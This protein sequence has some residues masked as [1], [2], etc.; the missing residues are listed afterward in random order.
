MT[1]ALVMLDIVEYA[2]KNLEYKMGKCFEIT[3]GRK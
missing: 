3:M 1:V 2:S